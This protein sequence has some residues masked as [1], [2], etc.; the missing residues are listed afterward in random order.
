M[1]GHNIYRIG[2]FLS[3]YRSP[4]NETFI[5]MAIVSKNES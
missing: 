2:V 5:T 4:Q 1:T 3:A